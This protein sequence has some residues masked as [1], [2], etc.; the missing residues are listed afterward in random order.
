MTRL[1][2]QFSGHAV[3]P[4]LARDMINPEDFDHMINWAF[5][6]ELILPH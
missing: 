2:P 1:T 5:V 4:S 3:I 6:S